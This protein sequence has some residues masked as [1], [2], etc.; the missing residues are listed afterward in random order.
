MNPVVTSTV[1]LLNT[2]FTAPRLANFRISK[3]AVRRGTNARKESLRKLREENSERR[4]KALPVTY[5]R[6]KAVAAPATP[7]PPKEP[8]PKA[9]N[10]HRSTYTTVVIAIAAAGVRMLPAPREIPEAT[11]SVQGPAAPRNVTVP[12]A[13]ALSR[14][15]S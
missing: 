8:N 2:A 4:M 1:T 5:A 15:R 9:A 7:K 12:Y 10:G 11:F 14:I 6:T 3:K 13:T